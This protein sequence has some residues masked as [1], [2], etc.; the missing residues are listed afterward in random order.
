MSHAEFIVKEVVTKAVKKDNG[1]PADFIRMHFH[2]CFVRGCDGSILINSTSKNVA[3]KDSPINN[4]SVEG[5]DIIDEV[6]A[7]LE[8]K[9][10]G[11]VSCADIIAFAAR[12]SVELSGGFAYEVP[13]GRRDGRISRS[14]ETFGNLAP[15]TFNLSQLT[16]NFASKGLNLDDLVTL[17]GA[18]TIGKSH[19]TSIDSR[20][21]NFSSTATTDPSLDP[22]YAKKLKKNPDGPSSPQVF[23]SSYY[24]NILVHKGLFQSDQSLLSSST[25]ANLVKQNAANEY[26]F[27]K[28]FAEAMVKMGNIEVLTG[29][30]GEIRLN[31][32]VIN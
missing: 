17:S 20:L 1:L 31:C 12:D 4:P 2:D 21:H 11:V 18:H 22:A 8:K 29:K 32:G 16:Q 23:D 10:K 7:K 30:K 13:S 27:K 28:R 14:S 19:C 15:P 5:F 25:T 3:E 9:C 26:L 24:K 6:K